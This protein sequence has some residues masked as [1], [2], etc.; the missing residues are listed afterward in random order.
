MRKNP[1]IFWSVLLIVIAILLWAYFSF[2][3]EKNSF[4]PGILGGKN[5]TER[6]PLGEGQSVENVSF[7]EKRYK[8]TL[9]G[10]SFNYL[11]DYNISSFG[12]FFDSNGETV[13]LQKGSGEQGLQILITPFD[14]DISLTA[15]RIKKD[16][17]TLSVIEEK[18]I[19]L[20]QDIKVQAV[21]FQSNNNLTTGKSLEAWFV[22]RNNL[23]QVSSLESSKELFDK[24]IN[25]WKLEE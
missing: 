1:Q 6:V 14:E 5:I 13:L 11:K 2:G 8:H 15:K 7:G 16:L 20:G 12:N 10:F 25:S 19:Q 17:P 23:Y 9:L 22:Y 24:V 21:V 4:L 3:K 18:E